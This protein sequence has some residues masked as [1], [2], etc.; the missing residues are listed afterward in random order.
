MDRRDFLAGVS[1]GGLLAACGGKV[2]PPLPPGSLT[3]ANDALGHRLR[4]PDFPAPS[5]TRRTAVAIVGGGIGG[6]SAACKLA[7]PGCDDLRVR[8]DEKKSA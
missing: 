4:K 6:L 1:A 2:M 3:G 8:N 7:R 5:E